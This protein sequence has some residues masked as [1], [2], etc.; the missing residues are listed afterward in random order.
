MLFFFLHWLHCV[1]QCI[2]FQIQIKQVSL[3]FFRCACCA[4]THPYHD[5]LRWSIHCAYLLYLLIKPHS[6]TMEYCYG[7]NY[8]GR[9]AALCWF[10]CLLFS[11]TLYCNGWRFHPTHS[12]TSHPLL[13]VL[14]APSLALS[15]LSPPPPPCSLSL[16]PTLSFLFSFSCFV[17]LDK[18]NVSIAW[19]L[20]S[21]SNK[22]FIPGFQAGM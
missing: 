12:L 10:V 3:W 19:P 15:L 9:P 20:I 5:G 8:P 16:A 4:C 2:V 6:S 1:R 17:W 21:K 14:C 13:S 7:S 18:M 22:V 11:I